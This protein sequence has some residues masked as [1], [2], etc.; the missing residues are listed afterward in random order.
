MVNIRIQTES[1][2]A[3]ISSRLIVVGQ[4]FCAICQ[5]GRPLPTRVFHA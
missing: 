3:P 2:G 4:L 1:F 5:A